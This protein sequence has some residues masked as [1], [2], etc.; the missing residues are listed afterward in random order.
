MGS[1]DRVFRK[2]QDDVMISYVKHLAQACSQHLYCS[3][4]FM[5]VDR[6]SWVTR[7]DIQGGGRLA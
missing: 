6:L 2:H 3:L 5:L 7:S 1:T 4:Q